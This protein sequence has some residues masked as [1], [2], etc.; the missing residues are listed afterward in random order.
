MTL[1]LL[2]IALAGACW[3][4]D[5]LPRYP[6]LGP[7]GGFAPEDFDFDAACRDGWEYAST[8][9]DARE[10][11]S[12]PE[13]APIGCWV[14]VEYAPGTEHIVGVG[15]SAP[16]CGYP[17][18]ESKA[19]LLTRAAAYERI[20]TGEALRRGDHVPLELAC[21]LPD[22]I[23][24][25]A[26][27]ANARTLRSYAEAIVEPPSVYPYAVAG[28]FGYGNKAQNES[29]L[30]GWRPGDACI[31]LSPAQ[32]ELLDV[33]TIR[34]ARIAEA[35]QA[36]IAPMVSTSGGAVHG[37]LIE[38]FMLGHLAHC[39]GGVPQDRILYDPCADHT[40]TNFRNTGAIL[41]GMGARTAYLVTDDHLQS[42]YMQE[43][44]AFELV[45]GSIDQ[46]A[47]RDWG[48]LVGAWRQASRGMD[49]GFWYTPYRFWSEP[50]DGRGSF[51]CV[52]DV[53]YG[54]DL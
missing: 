32:H 21:D 35:Y 42:K 16:G 1:G 39:D 46:R 54:D 4:R 26:A 45:G 44:T 20:A 47:L 6:Q 8:D 3:D 7:S 43:W 25:A 5:P 23:R 30:L 41:K 48:Y 19:R 34:A 51:S 13:R 50:R 38:A 27:R 18:S 9:P 22:D 12:F 37:K 36:G 40:H 33:N 2:T 28:T 31:E 29:K 49:A 15:P 52:G 14:S 53:P 10:H 11:V 24:R 17:E